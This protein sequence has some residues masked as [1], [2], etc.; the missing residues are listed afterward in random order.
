LSVRERVTRLL[1]SSAAPVCVALLALLLGLPTLRQP[2]TADDH[3]LSYE[4]RYGSRP[5]MSYG[6]GPAELA[7]LREAGAI[8]WWSNP[9]L[10]MRLFRPLSC[11]THVVEF[12]LWPDAAWAMHLVN[13]LL[14]ALLIWVAGLVY[15]ELLSS[16]VLASVAALMFALDD[17]HGA[18]VG[19]ISSRNSVLAVLFALLA[20]LLH[21]RARKRGRALSGLSAL[22]VALALLAGEGGLAAMAYLAAYALVFE[23]GAWLARLRGITP[24]LAVVIAWALLYIVDGYGVHGSSTYREPSAATLLEGVLD[25]PLWLLSLF[26]PSLVSFSVNAPVAGARA[27]ALVLVSPILIGLYRWLPR[28]QRNLF[29]GVALVFCWAPLFF[30]VPND[31]VT[32]AASFAAFGWIASVLDALRDSGSWARAYRHATI[33]LHFAIAPLCFVLALDAIG[34]AERGTQALLA[35]VRRSRPEQVVLVNSPFELLPAFTSTLL[36]TPPGAAA[37]KALH[38]LYAGSARLRVRRSAPDALEVQATPGWGDKPIERFF[39]AKRDLPQAGSER[40]VS[41]MHITVLENDAD[42]LPSRVRFR[43]TSE[44]ESPT[45]LW[46]VW[47]GR[48]PVAWRPPALGEQVELPALSLFSALPK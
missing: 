3:L 1:D 26:G 14:Y 2:L 29:F 5:L 32:I 40:S 43:F 27:V 11:L 17:A 18:A 23:S 9:K 47:E 41:G 16:R 24:Q 39:C 13:A 19:W 35:A 31:R 8:S 44:L 34:P 22:C 12:R 42:G 28:T 4:S 48:A 37:P 20:V 15:R 38:E 33:V 45:R 10:Q 21:V 6:Y 30:I 46:L 25:L 36:H 7:T